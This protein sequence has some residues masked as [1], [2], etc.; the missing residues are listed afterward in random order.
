MVI[1]NHAA[2]R[3]FL[4]AEGIEFASETDT[5]VLA[6][7]IGYYYD[8]H[9]DILD[10]VRAALHDVQGTFGA[11][12]L[13]SDHPESLIAARRGS[14]LAIGRGDGETFL[15]SDAYALAPFT[16]RV[17]Y[18]EDGDWTVITRE[19][20]EFFDHQGNPV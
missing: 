15:G 1:E 14:P 10:S 8:R 7:L 9:D 6:Q 4:T 5:E 18:L 12:I 3:E 11:A 20:A 16:N 17:T 19:G 2:I 13:C